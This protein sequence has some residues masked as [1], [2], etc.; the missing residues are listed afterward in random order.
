MHEPPAAMEWAAAGRSIRQRRIVAALI[1]SSEARPCSGGRRK[2]LEASQSAKEGSGSGYA[3]PHRPPCLWCR[4]LLHSREPG[5]LGSSFDGLRTSSPC[6]VPNKY[7][8]G[9]SPCSC[10]VARPSPGSRDGVSCIMRAKPHYGQHTESRG[11]AQPASR[12]VHPSLGRV[13]GVARF[14]RGPWRARCGPRRLPPRPC[15][16]WPTR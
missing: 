7:A 9:P 14:S 1:V 5:V 10:P 6:E 2:V 12:R 4:L 8:S 13:G 11:Y 16:G 3:L 15:R